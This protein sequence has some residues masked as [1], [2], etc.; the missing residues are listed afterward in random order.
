M[1]PADIGI[2]Y[3][4][5]N[6]AMPELVKIGYTAS[7]S[8]AKRIGELSANTAIPLPFEDLVSIPVEHPRAVERKIHAALSKYRVSPDRE[9]FRLSELAAMHCVA[10]VLWPMEYCPGKDVG[11]GE[12]AELD[13][14][15]YLRAWLR[16][17][18]RMVKRFPEYFRD[19]GL[20]AYLLDAVH[21]YEREHG[22]M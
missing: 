22:E 16:H 12:T 15:A 4:F 20:C 8:T 1:A 5:T 17:V 14:H 18:D 19:N 11:P 2:V 21:R 3:V 6:P 13:L 10:E 9:F 7:L